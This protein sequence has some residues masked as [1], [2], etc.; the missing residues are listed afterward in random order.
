MSGHDL[1]ALGA[2]FSRQ[3]QGSQAVFRQALQ[4]LSQPGRLHTLQH[5]AQVPAG[6]HAAAAALLLALLD[7]EC[8]LWLSPRLAGSEAGAWLR[9]HTGCQITDQPAQAHFAW[10]A[11][12]DAVPALTCFA[13]GSEVHPEGSTTCVLELRHLDDSRGGA[14]SLQGPGIRE[15]QPLQVEGLPDDFLAQW[16]ANHAAFPCGIDLFLVCG[17]QLAGLPRSTSVQPALITEEA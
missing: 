9:F 7:S 12:G 6:A 16:Q 5:D 15:R 1:S 8:R 4:A 3:A 17:D 13:Q 11:E 14:W 2:G 10:L